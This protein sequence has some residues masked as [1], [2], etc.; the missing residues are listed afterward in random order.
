HRATVDAVDRAQRRERVRVGSRTAPEGRNLRRRGVGGT[1]RGG[2][3][4][5]ARRG[6]R[7]EKRTASQFSSGFHPGGGGQKGG[8]GP[9]RGGG[10]GGRTHPAGGST[11]IREASSWRSN[12][13]F[14]TRRSK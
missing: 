8:C 5:D 6:D 4:R 14:R 1:G 3:E 11:P 10:S 9:G 12:A 13:S 2:D 7:G